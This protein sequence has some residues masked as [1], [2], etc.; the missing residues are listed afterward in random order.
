MPVEAALVLLAR[1]LFRDM[2]QKES[3]PA[4]YARGSLYFILTGS[5]LLLLLGTIV[6]LASDFLGECM[7]Q[8]GYIDSDD[9]DDEDGTTTCASESPAS[10]AATPE[11]KT[12]G[13]CVYCL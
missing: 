13:N 5:F 7:P 6:I 2:K 11:T 12:L 1:C 3:K 9:E 10:V 8:F 4:Y